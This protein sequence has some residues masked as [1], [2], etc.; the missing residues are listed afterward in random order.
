MCSATGTLL[1]DNMTN[2]FD[3]YSANRLALIHSFPFKTTK[4]YVKN[5]VFVE[6]GK[7]MY[8]MWK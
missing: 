1:V 4:K 8:C 6:D 7:T 2:G 5:G 3:L